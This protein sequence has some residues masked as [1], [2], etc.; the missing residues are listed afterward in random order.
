[1]I[2]RVDIGTYCTEGD[3]TVNISLPN[4]SCECVT[5]ERVLLNFSNEGYVAEQVRHTASPT[6]TG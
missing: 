3:K 5:L 2:E 1:M 6:L 4:C